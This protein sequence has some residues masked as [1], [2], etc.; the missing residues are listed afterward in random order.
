MNN[1]DKLSQIWD[2]NKKKGPTPEDPFEGR[3][4]YNTPQGYYITNDGIYKNERK[5]FPQPAII[6]GRVVNITTGREKLDL[7]FRRDR[8]EI[9][10]TV[11]RED[12]AAT[13]K[14]TELAA[15]GLLVNSNNA[16]G[17]LDFLVCF[18]QA[19]SLPTRKIAEKTGWHENDFIPFTGNYELERDGQPFNGFE[20]KGDEASWI[21]GIAQFRMNEAFRF[22]L[23]ASFAAPLLDLINHRIFLVHLWGS[24]RSGKTAALRAALSVWGNPE[25]LAITFNATRVG[26]ERMAAF[27]NDLPLAIDEKQV[28]NNQDFV[29]TLIYLLSLGKGKV[30]GAKN[31]GLQTVSTWR[32]IVLSTGEEPLTSIASNEGV[33]TR[34]VELNLKPFPNEEESRR[35]Y[36]IINTNY[37]WAGRRWIE[38]IKNGNVIDWIK[39]KYME[40]S[41]IFTQNHP[42]ALP[43]H[44]SA[45]AL[46][47]AVDVIASQLLFG[48]QSDFP[49]D[50]AFAVG[51]V[52]LAQSSDVQEADAGERA[53]EYVIGMIN[54]HLNSFH[55]DAR[56]RW[57][58]VEGDKARFF[59]PILEN[60]LTKGNFNYR[61]ILQ[62]WADKGLIT[63]SFEADRLRY[64]VKRGLNGRKLRVV[65]LALRE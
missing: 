7:V 31:G 59:P 57:G 43:S 52:I 62:S 53:Y 47:E 16:R 12:L 4:E 46:V 24:S 45:V 54:A 35:C 40:F 64:T 36:E 44:V 23:A 20:L 51:N 41:E 63:T 50:M 9:A 3:Y 1:I 61:K 25:E 19:N 49:E 32:T 2:E 29:E 48:E 10:L 13:R 65:E 26:L 27:Y 39:K 17:L 22:I 28:T 15:Y 33:Y 8:E 34:A 60:L 18:E 5:I 56:E 37:G 58:W 38:V 14:I 11:P 55:E 42:Q 6:A 21:N 30:R